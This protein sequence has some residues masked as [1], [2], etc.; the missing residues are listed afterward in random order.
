M[1]PSKSAGPSSHSG[2]ILAKLRRTASSREDCTRHLPTEAT[3]FVRA[4]LDHFVDDFE[5]RTRRGLDVVSVV[6]S[7]L[8]TIL[9][10]QHALTVGVILA[11]P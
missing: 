6:G 3:V 10:F 2:R 11:C 8:L 4:E 9:I 5:D 7:K 1:H